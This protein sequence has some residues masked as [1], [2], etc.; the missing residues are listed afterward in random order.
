MSQKEKTGE[1]IQFFR[2]PAGFNSHRGNELDE[3]DWV[4]IFGYFMIKTFILHSSLV[5]A[6]ASPANARTGS[7]GA[8]TLQAPGFCGVNHRGR[9]GSVDDCMGRVELL[10]EM[11]GVRFVGACFAGGPAR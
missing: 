6:H 4:G 8:Q 2:P 1:T 5:G 7:A 9:R 3:K 10:Q 11:G